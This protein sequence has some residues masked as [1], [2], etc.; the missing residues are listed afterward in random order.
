M[1]HRLAF[2]F[3]GLSQRAFNKLVQDVD[4]YVGER[5]GDIIDGDLEY[6]VYCGPGG[7]RGWPET[8]V[9]VRLAGIRAERSKN[10]R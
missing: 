1:E 8:H 10:T 4:E 9:D 2:A 5:L 7:P 6:E 3:S